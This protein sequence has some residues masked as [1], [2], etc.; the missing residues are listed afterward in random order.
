L[1]AVIQSYKLYLANKASEL[2]L[3]EQIKHS[4]K[5]TKKGKKRK[6]SRGVDGRG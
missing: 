2:I 4:S 6:E 1:S 3:F 5:E